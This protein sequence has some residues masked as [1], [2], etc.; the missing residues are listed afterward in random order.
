[1]IMIMIVIV[2]IMIMMMVIKIITKVVKIIKVHLE[3]AFQHRVLDAPPTT[4]L[5][6]A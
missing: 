4:E 6:S 5:N 1:M 3:S 2:I